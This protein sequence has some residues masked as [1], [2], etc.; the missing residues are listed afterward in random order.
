MVWPSSVNAG[1]GA[2]R[3]PL[4]INEGLVLGHGLLKTFFKS[5]HCK[6][7]MPKIRSLSQKLTEIMRFKIY[8]ILR[9]GKVYVAKLS[10]ARSILKIKC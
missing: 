1:G 5:S 2:Q 6:K 10:L 8:L 9:F 3:P 4:E 7:K